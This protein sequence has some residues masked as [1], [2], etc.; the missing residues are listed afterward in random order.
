MIFLSYYLE[1]FLNK[2]NY[3]RLGQFQHE[4]RVLTAEFRFKVVTDE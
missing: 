4:G 3:M 2:K 1:I